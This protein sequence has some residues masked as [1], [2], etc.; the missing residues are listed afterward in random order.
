[1]VRGMYKS[2]TLRRVFRKTPGGN[3]VIHYKRRKPSH[4]KCGT[5]K[6][7]LKGVPRE[8]PSVLASMSKSERKP[9]RPYGGNLCSACTRE[10]IKL[11]T[12]NNI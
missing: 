12:R 8:I 7:I 2:R 9:E 5:C 10:K 1:M 6:T 11:Q 4:A 3:N